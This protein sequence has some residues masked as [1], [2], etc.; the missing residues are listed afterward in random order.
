MHA[1]LVVNVPSWQGAALSNKAIAS[2]HVADLGLAPSVLA[3]FEAVIGSD[4]RR[5][6]V[7]A[8]LDGGQLQPLSHVRVEERPQ[9]RAHL[10]AAREGEG[11]GGALHGSAY[12]LISREALQ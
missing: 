5:V 6:H 3:D 9:L 12:T 10:L 1:K 8:W 2:R 11:G 7:C 4:S